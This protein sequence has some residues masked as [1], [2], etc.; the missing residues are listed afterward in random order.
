MCGIAGHVGPRVID[1]ATIERTLR[2]MRHRGPDAAAHRS[3]E[4]AR[5][6]R[7]DLLH[8]RLSILDLDPRGEQ[9][10][11]RGAGWLSYNGELYNYV[12][13][14]E[15]LARLGEAFH[16]T[17]DTEV[18][19]AVLDRLGLDGLD[20]CEGMW[21]FAHYDERERVLA[22]SRDRF[23]EKP[24]YLM[25]EGEDLYFGSEPKFLVALAGRTPA[26]D[27][28]HL[29]RFLVHGYKSLYKEPDTFFE[30]V[31]EL[32]PGTTM[33]IGPD[34]DV[35]TARYW[36]PPPVAEHD[37]SFEEAVA[38]TR[39]R[40]VRSVELRLRAD[41]PLAFC[42]SGGVDSVSLISIASRELGERVHGFTVVNR[43]E[44][45][46]EQEMVDLAVS[47]L[48]V[49]HTEVLAR[50]ESFL[51]TLRLL[52]RQH[53][54][55]VLTIAYYV[56]WMLMRAIHEAG[57]RVSVSGTAADELFTGYFDHHLLYL[58]AVQGDAELAAASREAWE[59]HVKPIVRN[60]HLSN[61]RLFVDDPGFRDHIYLNA[62]EFAATL[63]R[64]F[65]ESF[66]EHRY[67]D[68]LLRNRMLNEL[69]HEA[70]PVIL[71][72]DDHN[73]MSFSIENRSPFLDRELFEFS[74]RIPDRHLVRDGRAKAVLREAMRGIAPDPILDS[75]RKV[76]FN[77]PILDLLDTSRPQVRATLLEDSPIFDVVRR[78]AVEALLDRDRLPNSA[79]KF[80]FYFVNAKLFLEEF[81]GSPH[82]AASASTAA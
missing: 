18:L 50:D 57:Y 19:A 60:P 7:V 11:S 48:G 37:M 44:R 74:A 71:H 69:F 51:D 30:G 9:P 4:P 64:P 49:D 47:E 31:T 68:R 32:P 42:M 2:V 34:G 80:L 52:V 81:S 12:E 21:A 58:H 6:R 63:T 29:E 33:L 27:R 1:E 46:A 70:V 13:V 73:A 28:R 15:E 79:S 62:D 16:T 35:R 25:W 39:E 38:G 5:G 77:A 22:L 41:V 66:H 24:L 20:R 17:C 65:G 45:Y 59:T 61:P 8:R 23:G 14:R 53:D 76:G 78:D 3:F 10:F 56:H 55:P 82:A 72:E 54:G 36:E 26:V 40:L 43:D 67:S 75:P